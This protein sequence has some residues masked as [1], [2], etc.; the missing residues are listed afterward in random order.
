MATK[1]R[2]PISKSLRFDVFQRDHFTCQYCGRKAPDVVLEVD[3]IK[4][5]ARGGGNEITNLVTACEECNNGKSA[6]KLGTSVSM[7]KKQRELSRLAERREQLE[8]LCYWESKLTDIDA[9]AFSYAIR[10]CEQV[11]QF[12]LSDSECSILLDLVRKYDIET[13]VEAAR[14]SLRYSDKGIGFCVSMTPKI[15]Y[16]IKNKTCKQCRFCRGIY[17]EV[18]ECS[19]GFSAHKWSATKCDS[20]VSKYEQEGC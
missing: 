13:T 9:E 15:A 1:K 18:V 5:V 3:H 2:K 17:S 12:A 16:N 4:P 6:K 7:E 8:W 20:Y 11:Y 19:K 14:R 10:L